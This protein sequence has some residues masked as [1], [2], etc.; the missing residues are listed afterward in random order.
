MLNTFQ[1]AIRTKC[2]NVNIEMKSRNVKIEN[3]HNHLQLN[4]IFQI[5]VSYV[6][7]QEYLYNN[8]FCD[9]FPQE[10]RYCHEKCQHNIC[11]A[12]TFECGCNTGYK[13][14]TDGYSCHP[15]LCPPVPQLKYCPAN[16]ILLK[17]CRYP[18]FAICSNVSYNF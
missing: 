7:M 4:F 9:I 11:N 10:F 5:N 1:L 12:R 18:S 16:R 8:H 13:L 3:K 2:K 17:N 15:I 6:L 14:S